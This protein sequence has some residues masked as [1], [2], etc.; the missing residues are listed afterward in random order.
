MKG[1]LEQF[2]KDIASARVS[3][4]ISFDM[5]IAKKIDVGGTPAFYVDGQLISWSAKNG[6]KGYLDNGKTVSWDSARSGSAF[7]DLL[8]EIVEAKLA[9]E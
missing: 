1:D 2:K 4:K 6:G 3:K 7:V 5:N 8:K 9:D